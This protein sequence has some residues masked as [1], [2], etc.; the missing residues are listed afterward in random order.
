MNLM[1]MIEEAAITRHPTPLATPY[2]QLTNAQKI[3]AIAEAY[4][5][6]L[7]TLE[8]DTSD[9]SLAQTPLRVAKMY[10]EELFSGLDPDSFP[11]IRTLENTY[12]EP[13]EGMVLIEDISVKSICEHHFVPFIGN[14]KVAYIPNGKILG[15][16]KINRVVHYFCRRP[17]LQERLNAQIAD[18]LSIL[19]DTTDVAVALQAEHFCVTMR[20]V[21]DESS[22]TKT[23][24]LRGQ[25]QSCAHLRSHFLA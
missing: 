9:P 13:E 23:H 21:Q 17:Q 22:I 10:V 14:A 20:G 1:E 11:E 15:L 16:S 25:F 6:I 18:S 24:V 8:L 4:E 19:L 7:R 2:P 12:L 3:E 5:K